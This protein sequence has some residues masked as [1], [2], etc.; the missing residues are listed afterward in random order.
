MVNV[1]AV[2]SHRKS[3]ATSCRHRCLKPLFYGM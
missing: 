2:F 3:S 1:N